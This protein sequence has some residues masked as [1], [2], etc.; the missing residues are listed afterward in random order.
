MTEK[1]GQDTD[2]V[3]YGVR[4]ERDRDEAW[5]SRPKEHAMVGKESQKQGRP[6]LLSMLQAGALTWSCFMITAL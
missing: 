3:G 4:D 5:A 2:Q 1:E 6:G